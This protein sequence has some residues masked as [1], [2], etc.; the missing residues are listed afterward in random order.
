MK[1]IFFEGEIGMWKHIFLAV[2]VTGIAVVILMWN[3]GS[4][5]ALPHKFLLK[6]SLEILKRFLFLF[7]PMENI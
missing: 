4:L 1:D 2:L 5:W 7:P 6:I 3:A